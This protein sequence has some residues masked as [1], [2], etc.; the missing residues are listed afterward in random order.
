[1]AAMTMSDMETQVFYQILVS[2]GIVPGEV[3]N[4]GE[5]R[6]SYGES[7]APLFLFQNQH[8]Q[9]QKGLGFV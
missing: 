3:E 7:C 8:P 1:M 6:I 5:K 2:K 4:C 9:N